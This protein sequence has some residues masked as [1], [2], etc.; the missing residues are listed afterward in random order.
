MNNL[1]LDYFHELQRNM[2]DI[3]RYVACHEANFGSFSIR[4][5]SALIDTAAF[6]DSVC[7]DFIRLSHVEHNVRRETGETGDPYTSRFKAAGKVKKFPQKA[8]GNAEFNMGDY[9]ILLEMELNLSHCE[10]LL[11]PYQQNYPTLKCPDGF[12]LNPFTQ[13]AKE[14]KLPWWE[15][16][17]KLKHDRINNFQE[18]TLGNAINALAATFIVLSFKYEEDFRGG[19]LFRETYDLFHPLYWEKAGS[20]VPV[21]PMWKDK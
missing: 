17:T 1:E 12:R 18:A 16:F 19:L 11:R 8:S 6:F 4:I 14:E 5:E 13:W 3:F 7:Q 20:I 15:A 21:V 2:T 9:R 10:V